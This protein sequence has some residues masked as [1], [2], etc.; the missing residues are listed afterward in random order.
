MP[1]P[2]AADPCSGERT[3]AA[4]TYLGDGLVAVTGSLPD[5]TQATV[6]MPVAV[7]DT[8]ARVWVDGPKGTPW[9]LVVPDA[10]AGCVGDG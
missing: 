4:V 10:G 6:T 5:G 7:F 1:E 9:R 3:Y 2:L 8:A